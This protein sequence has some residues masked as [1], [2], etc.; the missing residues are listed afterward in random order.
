MGIRAATESIMV[1]LD[2]KYLLL[3]HKTQDADES[4]LFCWW[5]FV[6]CLVSFFSLR[7]VDSAI[8]L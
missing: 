8:L 4:L 6:F 2:S 7:G 1:S 5:F 3:D